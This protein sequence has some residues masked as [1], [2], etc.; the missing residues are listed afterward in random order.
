MRQALIEGRLRGH[1]LGR[2]AGESQRADKG[3]DKRTT[4]H[5][6]G[7]PHTPELAAKW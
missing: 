4:E 2:A 7:I 3:R 1:R 5:F 6:Y